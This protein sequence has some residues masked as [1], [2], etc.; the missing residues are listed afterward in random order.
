[1]VPTQ[2]GSVLHLC[3]KFQVDSTF[4]SKVIKG[5]KILKLGYVHWRR[6]A[7][8]RGLSPLPNNAAQPP[9]QTLKRILLF[10]RY[11]LFGLFPLGEPYQAQ[12]RFYFHLRIAV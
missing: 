7:W 3:T 4:R 2:K 6:Q 10:L 11:R 9:L 12:I 5:P 1:M 8:A